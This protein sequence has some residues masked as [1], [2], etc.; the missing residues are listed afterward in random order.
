[1]RRPVLVL[2]VVQAIALSEHDIVLYDVDLDASH[3]ARY[4]HVVKDTIRR[5]GPEVFVEI[6]EE[7]M[8]ELK[9]ALPEVFGTQS[10]AEAS[11]KRFLT[12]LN[13]SHPELVEELE[14]LASSLRAVVGEIPMIDLPTLATV[15]HTYTLSDIAHKSSTDTKPFSACTSILA[16]QANGKVL[17][18]RS[19]DFHPRDALAKATVAID[20]YQK[21]S[22]LYRC[23]HHVPWPGSFKMTCVRPGAFSVA[24]NAR[25]Q[26]INTGHNTSFAELLKRMSPGFDLP[27]TLLERA[28]AAE[29]YEEALTLLASQPMLGSIYFTIAG[30]HGQGAVVTRFANSSSADVWALGSSTDIS[31]GQPPWL[32]VQTNVDHWVSLESGAYATHRRQHALD[33]LEGLGDDFLDK[34]SLMGIYLTQ[35]ARA[36]SENRTQPEDTGA[37]LRPDTIASLVIDPSEPLGSK[38]DS[39][40]WHVW[41]ETPTIQPPLS[42]AAPVQV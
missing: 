11:Q 33:L 34:H 25:G 24:I 29:T 16:R 4:A 30:A 5:T 35:A 42:L 10:L 12:A 21:G 28:M 32:R 14:V 2:L 13:S 27:F 26:G 36:G 3:P 6:Y 41:A 20:F 1:M 23:L 9:A 18:G 22:R 37:I 31:D 39:R 8:E 19:K 17:H 38:P 7:W 15:T 40:F